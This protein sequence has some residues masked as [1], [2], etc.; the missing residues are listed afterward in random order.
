MEFHF[1]KAEKFHRVLIESL[2][3]GNKVSNNKPIFPAR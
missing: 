3:V 2:D 1:V